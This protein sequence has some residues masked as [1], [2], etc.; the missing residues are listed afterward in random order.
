LTKTIDL[1]PATEPASAWEELAE[2]SGASPFARPGWVAA[3]WR[4]FGRGSMEVVSV[5]RAGALSA[6]IPLVARHGVLSSPTNWHT[7]LFAALS[8]DRFAAGELARAVLA[9]LPRRLDLR[10]IDPG[11]RL[12]DGLRAQ[13]ARAKLRLAERVV[14]RAPYVPTDVSWES[15]ERGLSRNRRKN[16]R[17][18]RAQLE[19]LG[20]LCF[21]VEDGSE[22]L[23]ELLRT[24]LRIEASG[25]KGKR[26]TAI[27]SRPETV[28]FYTDVAR[29]AA[30][31]GIL[32]LGFLRLDGE[33]IAFDFSLEDQ[34]SIYS[35]K[36]GYA[37]EHRALGPGTELTYRMIRHAFEGEARSYE[38][39]GD[40]DAF[41]QGWCNGYQ[42]ERLHLQFFS[43]SVPAAIDR[44]VQTRGRP[45]ARKL[46]GA[47]R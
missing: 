28:S 44:V 19:E 22:R 8:E 41:K 7:P 38:F 35:I 36:A 34:R 18:R 25:W 14:A 4:A 15:Y 12:V 29:W 2:R 17:K 42:R 9:R 5:R 32:R 16:L 46:A 23:H 47:M 21:K 30:E 13:G 6:A 11:D 31:R 1:H 43:G 45:V 37:D 20:E 27:V 24:A 33:P 39:L 40:T 10:F 26:R 3:W